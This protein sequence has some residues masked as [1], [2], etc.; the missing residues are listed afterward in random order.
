M[1]V[2]AHKH[3]TVSY[4]RTFAISWMGWMAGKKITAIQLQCSVMWFIDKQYVS[5]L[6]AQHWWVMSLRRRRRLSHPDTKRDTSIIMIMRSWRDWSCFIIRH[7]L[8]TR[9]RWSLLLYWWHHGW[10]LM[11]QTGGGSDGMGPL[12]DEWLAKSTVIQS[13]SIL[14]WYKDSSWDKVWSFRLIR[15]FFCA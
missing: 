5:C 12:A 1:V 9:L 14:I 3:G 8:K 10:N 13:M 2:H 15:Q 4:L 7:I 11:S 6:P